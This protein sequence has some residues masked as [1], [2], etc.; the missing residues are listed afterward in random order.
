MDQREKVV[1]TDEEWRR[2]LS[3]E[4]FAVTRKKGT[5]PAFT[6]KYWDNHAY[7]MYRCIC[8]GTEL[9]RSD[10]KFDSGTGWPSFTAPGRQRT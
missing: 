2:E 4:Q 6:G 10:E 1:K 3:P 7:G 9:F 5:E 8:C